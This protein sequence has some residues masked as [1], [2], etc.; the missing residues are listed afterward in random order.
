[1]T[2]RSYRVIVR[3]R[4]DGLDDV[5]RADLLA[6][7]HRHDMFSAKFTADGVFL[8]ERELVGFQFRYQVSSSEPSPDD[9]ELEVAM[10]AEELTAR[11]LMSRGIKGR[12][13]QVTLTN[14]GD[15]KVRPQRTRA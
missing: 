3:G 6:Q 2:E 8:Y 12:I 1:M 9:A 10:V 14:M 15:V 4:F 13:V 5:Q 7:Q 11:Q